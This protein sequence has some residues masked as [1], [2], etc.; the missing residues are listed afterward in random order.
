[1]FRTSAKKDSDKLA[2]AVERGD[3]SGPEALPDAQW[4]KWTYGEYLRDVEYASAGFIS[5]GAKLWDSIAIWGFNAPEWHISAVAG[6]FISCPPAGIY[7]TDTPDQVQYKIDHSNAAVLVLEDEGKLA[8]VKPLVD[9]MPD[10]KAIVMYGG[11]TPSTSS[12]GKA[13]I[14]VLSWAELMEKGKQE[15]DG[16]AGAEALKREE[17]IQ[18][19]HCAVLIYTSGTTG[20]PKAVMISHDT[21]YFETCCVSDTNPWFGNDPTQER[22]LSY[23]PLSHIAGML[24][25]ILTPLFTGYLLPSYGTVY[26]A[27]TNDLKD[28]TIAERLKFVRPTQF[29]GVP[30]VWE[31]VAEKLKTKGKETTGVKKQLVTWAKGLALGRSKAMLL[32]DETN[33]TAVPTPMMYPVANILLKKIKEALGLDKAVIT[34]TGAAPITVDTL[35]YF[36]ALGICICEVY[37]MSESCGATTWSTPASHQW[38]S[39]GFQL[40]GTEIKCFKVDEKDINKKTEC[41]VAADAL[42]PTDAEQGEICFRGRHTPK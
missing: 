9:Q 4:T 29:L 27:R 7:P 19:G 22:T 10:L 30:R 5:L 1:V 28:S 42:A 13:G 11:G 8:K 21:L 31:K 16:P 39:C 41:P 37:G 25:D 33:G 15:K 36:G 18:P 6:V 2:L 34:I 32:S 14:V 3:F 26:F 40:P 24:M 12:I 17:A 35:E 38:G 20:M 23:L